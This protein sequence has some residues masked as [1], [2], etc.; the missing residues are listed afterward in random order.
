MILS[1]QHHSMGGT[2]LVGT[3]PEAQRNSAHL[4]NRV[5]CTSSGRGDSDCGAGTMCVNAEQVVF[6]PVGGFLQWP[7]QLAVPVPSAISAKRASVDC[8]DF[9]DHLH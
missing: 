4:F 2:D 3:D 9:R 6:L 7:V 5:C 1:A 8:A